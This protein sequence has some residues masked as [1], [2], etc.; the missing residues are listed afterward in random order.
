MYEETFMAKYKI[1]FD[2]TFSLSIGIN[3]KK[4]LRKNSR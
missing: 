4:P 3:A 1:K 2:M